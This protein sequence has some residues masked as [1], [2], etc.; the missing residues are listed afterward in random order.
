MLFRSK[1]RVIAVTSAKRVPE[2]PDVPAIQEVPEL[3]GFDVLSW[4]AMFA[5]KGMAADQVRTMNRIMTTAL[6][7]PEVATGFT[8][9]GFAIDATS[10]EALSAYVKREYDKWGDVIRKNNIKVE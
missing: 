8:N 7:D 6:K 1:F 5:P 10:P 2:L 4:L 9:A 3:A